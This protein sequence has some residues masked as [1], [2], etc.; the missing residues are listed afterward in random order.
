MCSRT[1]AHPPTHTHKGCACTHTDRQPE[2][3]NTVA[4]A[5]RESRSLWNFHFCPN[6]FF[7]RV[8]GGG[9]RACTPE[10]AREYVLPSG[11]PRAVLACYSCPVCCTR[12]GVLVHPCPR[13]PHGLQT[14]G[15]RRRRGAQ[16]A[17]QRA[18]VRAPGP[19]AQAHE[20]ARQAH[21][22]GALPQPHAGD[23]VFPGV[24]TRARR[25]R[26]R[27]AQHANTR[28]AT[29]RRRTWSWCPGSSRC[30]RTA[31]SRMSIYILGCG[32]MHIRMPRAPAVAHG[33][34]RG[35]PYQVAR[36]ARAR[37]ARGPGHGGGDAGP[38]PDGARAPHR[39]AP[40]RSCARRVRGVTPPPLRSA[41]GMYRERRS[42]CPIL[43]YNRL[44]QVGAIIM[45]FL[46]RVIHSPMW[47]SAAASLFAW[48]A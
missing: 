6:T 33:G 34:R 12:A 14:R 45:C 42:L 3:G 37:A 43:Y 29:T 31:V 8:G 30:A 20:D 21:G 19:E 11:G 48:V 35:P 41:V 15:V 27:G 1:Q 46:F 38:R 40:R 17:S 36:R 26:S 39:C 47:Q 13:E 4:T 28:A 23:H 32:R 9:S 10:D 25:G 16:N 22:R 5:P 2:A 7:F 44:P 24:R 18:A